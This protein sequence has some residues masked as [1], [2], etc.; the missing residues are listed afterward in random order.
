MVGQS[1][2]EACHQIGDNGNN[3]PGPNLSNVGSKLPQAAITSTLINPTPPMPS[4]K[5][6]LQSSPKKFA[7]LVGFLSL[8][9]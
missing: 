1:G 3:G 6:L 7:Q 8:L 4:F 9:Q 2:C 5:G